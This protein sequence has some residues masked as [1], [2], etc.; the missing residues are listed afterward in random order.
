VEHLRGAIEGTVFGDGDK[1]SKVTKFHG[2]KSCSYWKYEQGQKHGIGRAGGGGGYSAHMKTAMDT[3]KEM[4][5]P[6]AIARYFEAA[7]RFDSAAA[8]AC[9][10]TDATVHDEGHEHVGRK[11]IQ[12]WISNAGENYQPHVT[13]LTAAAA[14][15]NFIVTARVSG[16]FPGS[17]IELNFAFV[18]RDGAIAQLKIQ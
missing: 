2:Q 10:A 7:N 16:K 11:A 15:D 4:T 13:V 5:L 14:D 17:P 6:G 9:C 1:V 12:T 18:L 3:E 8:A